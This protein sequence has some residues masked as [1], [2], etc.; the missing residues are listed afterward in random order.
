[1]LI[2]LR[3]G[4]SQDNQRLQLYLA[5]KASK[6]L[7][8]EDYLTL[9]LGRQSY[10]SKRKTCLGKEMLRCEVMGV[11]SI[12]CSPNSSRVFMSLLSLP[13]LTLTFKTCKH[14][15]DTFTFELKKRSETEV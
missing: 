3:A 7:V 8:F 5:S 9:K 13:P 15:N 11:I 10:K 12:C 14:I 4:F 1:M 6:Q 2:A